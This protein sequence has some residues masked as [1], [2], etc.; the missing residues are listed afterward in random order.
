MNNDDQQSDAERLRS[1]R[2]VMDTE[3]KTRGDH[4]GK[5][6]TQEELDESRR[7]AD[8]YEA[9]PQGYPDTAQSQYNIV[10]SL[11]NLAALYEARNDYKDAEPLYVQA[12]SIRQKALPQGHPDIV[13]SLYDLAELYES[14]GRVQDAEPLYVQALDIKRVVLGEQHPGYATAL[15]NLAVLYWTE[16]RVQD[17]EPLLAQAVDIYK[18]AY[19]QGYEIE[20]MNTADSL[21]NLAALYRAQGRYQDAEPLYVQALRIRGAVLESWSS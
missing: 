6:W 8:Q 16:G 14:Q 11:N 17:A 9:L 15:N 10:R 21:D 4:S 19:K 1:L 2:E 3:F 18:Q 7:I 13:Q 5:I 12:L 20:F